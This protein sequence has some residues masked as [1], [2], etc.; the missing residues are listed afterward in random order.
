MNLGVFDSGLGGLLIAKAIEKK[1]PEV[2]MVYLGDTLHVPYGNRSPDAIY[3]YS[4]R[5]IDHLFDKQNCNLIITACNTVSASVLRRLQQ[6]YLPNSPYKDRRIL[7]VVVPTLECATE[8]GYKS[9]GLLGTNH[10]IR[11]NVYREELAKL[12]PVL[13]LT[14]TAAPLLV[15]MIENEGIEWIEPVLRSYLSPLIDEKVECII[16]GCTH[17]IFLKEQIAEMAGKKTDLISQDEIIPDKLADYLDRHPE[18]SNPIHR[19]GRRKFLVTDYTQSYVN[20][21]KDIYGRN[22]HIEHVSLHQ[23]H[24]S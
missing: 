18:I 2:N 20:T 4:K 21:S 19:Q 5:C 9:L 15:P 16:L 22:I 3:E 13:E 10:T 8:R 6:E 12:D 24:S 7:G 1:L 17:Y 11:S 14:Q 23:D